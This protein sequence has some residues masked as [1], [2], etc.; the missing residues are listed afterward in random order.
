MSETTTTKTNKVL[1]NGETIKHKIQNDYI[2]AKK[3][4]LKLLSR[5]HLKN[6]NVELLV[7]I[8][9][10]IFIMLGERI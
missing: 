1:L 5:Y 7:Q 9:D 2:L 10:F 6:I 8:I 4:L 3:K